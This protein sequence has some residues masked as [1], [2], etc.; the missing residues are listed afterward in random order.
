MPAQRSTTL[1]LVGSA[2]PHALDHYEAG[3]PYDREIFAPGIAAHAVLQAVG[4]AVSAGRDVSDGVT[5]KIADGV[6][7]QLVTVGRSFDGVPEP[8][9]SVDSAVKGRD[10]AL[11]YLVF[12]PLSP[13]ARYEH[14]FEVDRNWRPVPYNS[15]NGWYR[16]AL[17]VID[18]LDNADEEGNGG[19]IV[20]V[21]DFKSAWP[22]DA[23]ELETVQL[24]GQAAIA[25]AYHPTAAIVR[26][27]VA[28]LRTGAT[29]S[30]DLP[31]DDE[32]LATIG[33]WRQDA[34]LQII[35]ADHRGP[36]GKRPARPGG[37]CV[38][39][40]YV[41]RCGPARAFFA[42]TLAANAA[43]APVTRE[44]LGARYAVATGIADHLG[45]LAK[46]A[47]R[48]APIRL[49]DNRYVGYAPTE[50]RKAR[51][52]APQVLAQAWHK[53]P[54]GD[55]ADWNAAHPEELGLLTAVK[56]G[57]GNIDAALVQLV[58]SAHGDDTWKER[59]AELAERLTETVGASEFG[60]HRAEP[61]SSANDVT[62][63]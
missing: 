23:D 20:E 11:R 53:V 59:R 6:V 37:G 5:E 54:A 24:R 18:V 63:S 34:D 62:D 55:A 17:D 30:A 42:D 40:P 32:G 22:T 25:V 58:P 2:C 44:Q 35:Q 12:H 50:R 13:S 4:E 51:A 36:D 1:K 27:T 21:L 43:G 26:R 39:C 49:P 15:E 10:I 41:G 29:Y 46:A 9:M 33:R 48:N 16:G 52:D 60:I 14:G 31:L 28:N 7:R 57:A 47:A 45:K 19:Q 61:I 3:A 38:A 56:L 8:P